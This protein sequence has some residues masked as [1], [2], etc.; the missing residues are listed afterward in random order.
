VHEKAGEPHSGDG[1]D[2]DEQDWQESSAEEIGDLDGRQFEH[3]RKR[4][5]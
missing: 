5:E 3:R 4:I 2:E 1:D